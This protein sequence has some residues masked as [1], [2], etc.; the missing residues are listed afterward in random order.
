M[1]ADTEIQRESKY[2][3][4]N[5]ERPVRRGCHSGAAAGAVASHTRRCHREFAN[6]ILMVR[7]HLVHLASTWCSLVV[8]MQV[9]QF[10]MLFFGRALVGGCLIFRRLSVELNQSDL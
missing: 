2:L 7:R 4:R 1:E 8:G 10:K 6:S 3:L 9:V 5:D